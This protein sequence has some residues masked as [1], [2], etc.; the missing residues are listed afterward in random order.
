MES[1][2]ECINSVRCVDAEEKFADVQTQNET[3]GKA[4]KVEHDPRVTKI[5]RFIRKTSIDEIPQLWNILKGDMSIIGICPPL[6]REVVLYTPYEMNRL[7]V[8]VGLGTIAQ[9]AGRSD[10]PF[11]EWVDLDITYIQKRSLRLDIK[12]FFQ[13]VFAVIRRDGAK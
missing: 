3:D 13:M 4:F 1:L 2:F 10:L 7:T 11:Q 12:I 8:K 9:V 5:G 6:P